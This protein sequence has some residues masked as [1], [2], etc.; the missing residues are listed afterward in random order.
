MWSNIKQSLKKKNKS[1][2]LRNY[3]KNIVDNDDEDDPTKKFSNKLS[4]KLKE[5]DSA[6]LDD[7]YKDLGQRLKDGNSHVVYQNE[8]IF[9]HWIPQ[10]ST[11]SVKFRTDKSSSFL[12]N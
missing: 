11:Y 6:A 4:K 1:L 2:I 10:C 5:L 3:W 12:P 7:I 8:I 9:L